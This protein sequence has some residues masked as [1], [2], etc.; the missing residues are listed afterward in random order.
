M[1][2]E[3]QDNIPAGSI[4]I[5]ID[6]HVPD[7]LPIQYASHVFVQPGEYEV[8]IYFFQSRFPL[9]AGTPEENLA[10]LEQLGHIRA[11]C[12]GNIVVN[13]DLIPKIIN[14]LQSGLDNYRVAKSLNEERSGE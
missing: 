13:P 11:E 7:E 3:R 8:A 12:V 6:W 9:L 14:A 5:P 10:K 1:N 2:E 4:N